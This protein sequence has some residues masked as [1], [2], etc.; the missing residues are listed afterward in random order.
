MQIES[1]GCIF[2]HPTSEG[3]E[4]VREILLEGDLY[5]FLCLCSGPAPG[6]YVFTKLLK[7]PIAFFSENRYFDHNL[8]R[9]FSLN[10]MD[11]RECSDVS[12]YSNPPNAG[13]GIC[14]KSKEVGDDSLIG[15][16]VS[17]YGH[18]FKEINISFLEG[19]LQKVKLQFLDLYQSLQV[20]IL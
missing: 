16:G 1:K 2:L 7:I 9:K 8:S 17:G 19:K 5:Q 20:S 11:S 12:G 15:D 10:L 3:V 4:E 18:K 6:P 13:A 14:D